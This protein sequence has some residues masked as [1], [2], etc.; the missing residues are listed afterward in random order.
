MKIILEHFCRCVLNWDIL[1]FKK[2]HSHSVSVSWTTPSWTYKSYWQ[3]FPRSKTEISELSV[4]RISCFH[5]FSLNELISTFFM[6][7]CC[8]NELLHAKKLLWRIETDRS[9][10]KARNYEISKGLIDAIDIFWK[11]VQAHV[12]IFQFICYRTFFKII[13]ECNQTKTIIH[14]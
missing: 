14:Q 8:I 6:S 3:T 13:H 1:F 7:T 5:C 9:Y 10:F 11:I 12:H 2:N 4:R